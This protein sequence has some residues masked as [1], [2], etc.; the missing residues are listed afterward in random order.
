[1]RDLTA[2]PFLDGITYGEGP[3]WH[4]GRLWFTDGV[5][6]KV[7]AADVEGRLETV[8]E[9]PHPSGLGW[10]PDGTRNRIRI[11]RLLELFIQN[12]LVSS[13]HIDQYQSA[14]VLREHVNAMQLSQRESQR[15]LIGIASR[16]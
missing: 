9:A 11:Q 12:A 5:V 3:R 7:M 8:L 14:L 10:L 2:S 1:M 16:S 6:R 4:E 15:V 13:M